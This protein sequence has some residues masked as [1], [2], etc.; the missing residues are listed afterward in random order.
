MNDT[1]DDDAFARVL[2]RLEVPEPGPEFET[3]MQARLADRIREYESRRG[4]RRWFGPAPLTAIA[5]VAA[6]L[7]VGFLVG[8][9]LGRESG[10]PEV[11]DRIIFVAVG[12]HLERSE[13][14]LFEIVNPPEDAVGSV[15]ASRER[16]G[17]LV[18]ENRILRAS[19]GDDAGRTSL[20]ELL[21]DLE[22]VLVE[23]A[24]GP[25]E[26]SPA[27]WARVKRR[28][29]KR[30]LL[31]RLHVLDDPAPVLPKPTGLDRT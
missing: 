17:A 15:P 13:R 18:T 26:P 1:R 10:A 29:E 25:D 5:S 16:V 24:N 21:E 31:L 8:W 7:L 19:L 20:S 9:R 30:G 27:D 4:W 6:V 11:R 12:D 3:R 2:D 14:L 23:I 28:I 22:T